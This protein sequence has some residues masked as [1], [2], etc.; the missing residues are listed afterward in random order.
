[1]WDAR[2]T[3]RSIFPDEEKGYQAHLFADQ[4]EQGT[5]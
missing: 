2:S 3:D 4:E 1:M 5:M